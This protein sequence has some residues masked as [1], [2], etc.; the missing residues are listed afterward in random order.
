[1]TVKFHAQVVGQSN[2]TVKWSIQ[3]GI[4]TIDSSGLYTAPRDAAGG[5]FSVVATSQAVPRAQGSADVTVLVPQ[6][7]VTPATI[8]LRPG[9]TP[10]FT[11]TV[12]GLPN[13]QVTW[14]VPEVSGGSVSAAGLY[15]AP[16]TL[17]F[18]HVV[19]TSMLD[20]VLLEAPPSLWPTLLA[21][22]R[23][24][25]ACRPAVFRTR[26]LC[27]QT[28]TC[29]LLAEKFVFEGF[30]APASQLHRLSFTIRLRAH[31][32]TQRAV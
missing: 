30:V 23:L 4:G 5:P 9:G 19:A 11:A 20:A 3:Q 32:L 18:Y 28:E 15:N 12:K 16:P 14:S 17:G 24:R 25:L 22:L 2:Q 26:E 29:W 8:T 21:G 31:S 10:T 6:V 27:L 1:M 7:A 13:T